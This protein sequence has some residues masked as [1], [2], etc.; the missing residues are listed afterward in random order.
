MEE[1]IDYVLS[2][3]DVRVKPIKEIL[4]WIRNPVPLN[5]K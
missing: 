5:K 4:D 1:F 2:K 3:D